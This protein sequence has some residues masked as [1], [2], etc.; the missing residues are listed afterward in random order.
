MLAQVPQTAGGSG[1]QV[2]RVPEPTEGETAGAGA[3]ADDARRDEQEPQ[4]G[5]PG[6]REGPDQERG[7]RLSGVLR[8]GNLLR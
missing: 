4:T 7:K 8:S 5:L 2:V 6:Q 3:A 1:Q